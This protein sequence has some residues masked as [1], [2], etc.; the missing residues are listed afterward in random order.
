MNYWFIIVPF[1]SL[2]IGWFA[3][4]LGIKIL[5]HP[6]E[7]K[8]IFGIRF[9]GIF[10]KRQKEFAQ[11][12]GKLAGAGFL[13]VA[14]IEKKVSDPENLKKIMTMIESNVDYFIRV[15]LKTEMP[16]LSTFIGDKTIISLK[17]VFMKEIEILFPQVMLEVATNVKT[18]LDIENI[19][20]KKIR[21]LSPDRLEKTLQEIMSKEFR[22]VKI[23]GAIIGFIIGV[24]QLL[25]TLLIK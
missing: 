22:M 1:F 5:F 14:D 7:P 23:M 8:R 13:S 11:K 25:I 10:P 24:V 20:V 2:F 12:A 15:K 17:T 3:S 18:E 4:W 9:H 21:G 19:V 16:I 6:H